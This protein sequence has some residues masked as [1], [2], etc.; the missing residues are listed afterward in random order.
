MISVWI[1]GMHA[2]GPLDNGWCYGM[3][4]R[5]TAQEVRQIPARSSVVSPRRRVFNESSKLQ[6]FDAWPG[7]IDF[8]D[9]IDHLRR[10]EFE[11][12]VF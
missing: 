7:A 12:S 11:G 5:T 6:I 8:G 9:T 2:F 10:E 3:S 4:S 1:T